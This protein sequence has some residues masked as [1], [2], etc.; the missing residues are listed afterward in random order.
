MYVGRRLFI[1]RRRTSFFVFL[2]F[3]RG[4]LPH[5]SH[6]IRQAAGDQSEEG[7]EIPRRAGIHGHREIRDAQLSAR[8]DLDHYQHKVST[9]RRQA[10]RAARRGQLDE[11]LRGD[12]LQSH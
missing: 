4:R 5:P 12:G 2:P 1:D 6:A 3:Q 7:E 9:L 10:E 8:I 11:T